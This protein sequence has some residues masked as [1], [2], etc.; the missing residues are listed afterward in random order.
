MD[1]TDSE[2]LEDEDDKEY[3]KEKAKR[4]NSIDFTIN[5]VRDK[6]TKRKK[7]LLKFLILFKQI[8][9]KKEKD[10]L[11]SSSSV[12]RNQNKKV[13]FSNENTF[14]SYDEFARF[15]K[16][17]NKEKVKYLFVQKLQPGAPF[18]SFVLK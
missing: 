18:H 16:K 2:S 5:K 9:T 13:N 11:S 4:V 1:E 10:Q 17:S 15:K 12:S 7:T 3:F 6:E 14:S 8:K